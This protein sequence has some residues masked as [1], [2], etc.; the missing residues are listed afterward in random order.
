MARADTPTLLSLDRYARMMG[1]NPMHF[2]GATTDDYFPLRNSCNDLWVQRSWD[3][4]DAVSREELAR[5]IAQAE[6][7]IANELGWWPAPKWIV[8]EQHR[9]PRHYRRDAFRVYGRNIRSMR[10]GV[11]TDYAKVIS[12]G[13]RATSAVD[14]GATVTYTDADGDGFRE[15][16]TVTA[17]TTLTNV[18]EVFAFTA[19]KSGAQTWE[20]RPARTKTISGGTLTMTFWSWQMIDPDLWD[21]FPTAASLDGQISINLSELTGAGPYTN[22]VGTVDVYRVYTDT[23]EASAQMIWEPTP[24]KTS[25]LGPDFCVTAS[26]CAGCRLTTQDGCFHIRDPLTGY[27]VPTPATYDE[28][29]AQW[30][31]VCFTENREP[32]SVK[33]WYYCGD[34]SQDYLSGRVGDPLDRKW[35]EAIAQLTTARLERQLCTCGN[36]TALTQKWQ[37]DA[38]EG[39]NDLNVPFEEMDNPFG[40]RLGELYAWRKVRRERQKIT[41]GGAV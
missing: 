15:T 8:Q 16:A 14:T 28:D 3:F 34:L 5:E 26:E 29:N 10:V 20:I 31:Q 9:Y 24:I 32:D 33:L 37:K 4:A 7:D 23:T 17:T 27:V 6:L 21:A 18:N 12:P 38:A 35:A 36:L 41:G 40:T 2:S 19:G 11:K 25:L 30:D 39:S 13:R 1:I 22:V